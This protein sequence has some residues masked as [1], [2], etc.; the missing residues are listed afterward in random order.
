MT[1][2]WLHTWRGTAT[3][4]TAGV[5]EMTRARM[6]TADAGTDAMAAPAA[7]A[8]ATMVLTNAC[9]MSEPLFQLLIL[10]NQTCLKRQ[11]SVA[12]L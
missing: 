6:S 4:C 7:T 3:C 12:G 8:E 11:S 5:L 2:A 9:V 1:A 10:V